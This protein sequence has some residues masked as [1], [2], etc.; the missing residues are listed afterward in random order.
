MRDGGR[1]HFSL[2]N[3]NLKKF[4]TVTFLEFSFIGGKQFNQFKKS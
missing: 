2:E 4:Q 3:H 1:W